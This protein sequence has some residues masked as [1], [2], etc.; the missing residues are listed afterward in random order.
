MDW[1]LE[2]VAAAKDGGGTQAEYARALAYLIA[3][4]NVSAAV[5]GRPHAVPS[6]LRFIFSCQ[7]R[8][9]KNTKVNDSLYCLFCVNCYNRF[10][11]V[12]ALAN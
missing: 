9:S 11:L 5:L 12:S 4:P 1:L 3:D 7:P 2:S 8:R 6:L 10:R